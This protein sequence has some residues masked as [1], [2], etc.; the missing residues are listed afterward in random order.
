MTVQECYAAMGGS[1]DEVLARLRGQIPEGGQTVAGTRTPKSSGQQVAP[2]IVHKSRAAGD[3]PAPVMK[4]EPK[5]QP[6]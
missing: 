2:R 6:S 3:G 1:Y 4:P 5:G